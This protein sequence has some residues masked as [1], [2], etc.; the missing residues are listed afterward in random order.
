MTP[1]I[2]SPLHIYVH[3]LKRARLRRIMRGYI[4]LKK[5]GELDRIAK[6]KTSIGR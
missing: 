6:G 5:S 4:K 3:K 2:R 1:M